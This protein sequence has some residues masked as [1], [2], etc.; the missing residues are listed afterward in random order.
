MGQRTGGGSV[1]LAVIE[2]LSLKAKIIVEKKREFNA[3][4]KR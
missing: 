1:I 3:N 4:T 2:A